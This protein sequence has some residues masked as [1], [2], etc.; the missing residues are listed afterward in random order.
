MDTI[1]QVLKISGAFVGVVVGAGFASGQEI[2]QF[3]TSFG[4]LGL[5]GTLLSSALFMYFAM[6]L[7]ILGNRRESTSHKEVIYLICGKYIGIFVDCVITA[8]MFGITV[9]MFSGAG[10]LIEQQTGLPL[11]WGSLIT[12]LLTASLVC[13]KAKNVISFISLVT[14]FLLII[15][16]IVCGYA[17]A[18]SQADIESMGEIASEQPHGAPNWLLA[19]FVYVSYMIV[20]G[21][22]ILVISG[23][24]VNSKKVAAWGGVIGGVILGVLMLSIAL[25]MLFQIDR[26]AGVQIPTL[27]LATEISPAL[28]ILMAVIIFGMILNTAVGVLYSFLARTVKPEPLVFN[29]FA[30][31]AGI[32]AFLLSQVGFSTL[33][34]TVYPI[35]GYLGFVLM[36]CIVIGTF[37]SS[38]TKKLINSTRVK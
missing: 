2:L 6:S 4:I 11:L 3:F 35:F 1:K 28:G 8:F 5:I 10:A 26:L 34:G 9:V 38:F 37:R 29:S 31:V 22:P 19:V 20:S 18:S 15:I 25:G 7:A 16:L 33:V 24:Q 27:K 32:I 36:I 30:I 14:P 21:A 13:M 23:G 17:I 12:A